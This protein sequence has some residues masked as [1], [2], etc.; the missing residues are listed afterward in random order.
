M[1]LPT[2]RSQS[3]GCHACISSSFAHTARL[4]VALSS[5]PLSHSQW[6][7]AQG[8]LLIT[9]NHFLSASPTYTLAQLA[10]CHA[11]TLPTTSTIRFLESLRTACSPMRHPKHLVLP[12]HFVYLGLRRRPINVLPFADTSNV[13]FQCRHHICISHQLHPPTVDATTGLVMC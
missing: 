11:R 2:T 8:M 4:L 9:N 10:Q 6:F 5:A 3:M 1:H 13:I 12:L 7:L